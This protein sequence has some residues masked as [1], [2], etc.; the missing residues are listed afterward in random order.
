MTEKEEKNNDII[1]KYCG[2]VKII[3]KRDNKNG[4]LLFSILQNLRKHMEHD[5]IKGPS[6]EYKIEYEFADKNSFRRGGHIIVAVT[7]SKRWVEEQ[8]R[9][10]LHHR[11]GMVMFT[12]ALAYEVVDK[13]HKC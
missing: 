5:R 8:T 10:S 9:Y 11:A 1:S 6:D 12:P 13:A 4:F 3:V 2:K 7:G